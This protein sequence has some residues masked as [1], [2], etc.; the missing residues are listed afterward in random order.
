M[1]LA[2]Y[3]VFKNKYR[4]CERRDRR[5]LL[6]KDYQF[7]NNFVRPDS[8]KALKRF[9]KAISWSKNINI[10][11]KENFELHRSRTTVYVLKL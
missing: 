9:K 2:Q 8:L 7:F 3:Y 11:I 4:S 5:R 6:N 1:I 10:V